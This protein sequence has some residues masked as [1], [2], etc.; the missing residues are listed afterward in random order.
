MI[1][2]EVGRRIWARLQG[3][4]EIGGRIVTRQRGAH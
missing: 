1:H 2:I 3:A 4:Q